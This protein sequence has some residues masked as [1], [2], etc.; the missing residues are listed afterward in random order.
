MENEPFVFRN[1]TNTI[2]SRLFHSIYSG[3]CL[4]YVCA[5]LFTFRY[6]FCT[7]TTA[8]VSVHVHT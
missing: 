3:V 1:N 8:D 4:W 7:D 5:L 2:Q 6:I